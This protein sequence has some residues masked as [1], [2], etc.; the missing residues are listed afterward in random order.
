MKRVSNWSL[1]VNLKTTQLERSPIGAV[2]VVDVA[3]RPA[4]PGETLARVRVDVVMAVRVVLT[5][6]RRTLVQLRLAVL[7]GEAVHTDARVAADAVHTRAAVQT[8]ICGATQDRP[9][10]FGKL[11]TFSSSIITRQQRTERGFRW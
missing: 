5:R 9:S 6:V 11:R 8:R 10:N 2:V 3:V 4:E 1:Q 7:S